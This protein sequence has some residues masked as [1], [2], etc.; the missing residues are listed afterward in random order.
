MFRPIWNRWFKKKTK[1]DERKENGK[2]R[3][4]Q[5]K[6]KWAKSDKE[7]VQKKEKKMI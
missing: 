1:K 7:K 3:E 2:M 4:N 6:T 5:R